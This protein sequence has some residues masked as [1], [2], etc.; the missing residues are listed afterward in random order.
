MARRIH[1]LIG[2]GTGPKLRVGEATR[3]HA[4]VSGL[5]MGE[6][7]AYVLNKNGDVKEHRIV[8]NGSVELS[9]GEWVQFSYEGKSMAICSIKVE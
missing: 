9:L 5:K 7:Y 1:G 3:L 6:V 2:P 8:T 4:E